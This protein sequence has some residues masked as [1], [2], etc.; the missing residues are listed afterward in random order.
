M[1]ISGGSGLLSAV[2][3][4][5][6]GGGI[7]KAHVDLGATAAMPCQL[8]VGRSTPSGGEISTAG[9]AP[10]DAS[11]AGLPG[12]GAPWG[13]VSHADSFEQSTVSSAGVLDRT[14]AAA[15]IRQSVFR[16]SPEAL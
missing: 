5:P 6:A 11:V 2:R 7:R 16:E 12:L 3:K 10:S 13:L 1:A 9:I 14:K 8:R 15:R 4:R